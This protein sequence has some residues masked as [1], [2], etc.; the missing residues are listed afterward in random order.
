MVGFELET[1]RLIECGSCAVLFVRRWGERP[2][3]DTMVHDR[4][5]ICNSY[6]RSQVERVLLVLLWGEWEPIELD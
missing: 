5:G 4:D 2:G 1:L 6:H 3:V